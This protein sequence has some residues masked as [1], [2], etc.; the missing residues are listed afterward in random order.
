MTEHQAIAFREFH[1]VWLAMLSSDDFD[2]AL[3]ETRVL[4]SQI[5]DVDVL[6]QLVVLFAN[7]ALVWHD[8]VLEE[9]EG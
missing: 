6:R 9:L 2:V 8:R 7:S 4:L 1:L 5:D 3:H